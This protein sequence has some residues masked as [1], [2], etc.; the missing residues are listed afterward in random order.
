LGTPC[1][2]TDEL[3]FAASTVIHGVRTSFWHSGWVA[4]RRPKDIALD[5]CAISKRKNR[6]LRDALTANQWIRDI[7]TNTNITV[8]H[9]QQF[10]ELW[11]VTE[12]VQLDPNS[13]DTITWRWTATGEYSASS[14]Y[15]AKFA[16]SIKTKLKQIIWKP[17]ALQKC[18]FFAWLVTKYRVWTSD[19][20]A[21]R[22]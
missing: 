12:N 18:K 2:E 11:G 13:A 14:A 4:G 19:R 1:D 10:V 6:C 16:G 20:L 15:R 5:V 9:I 17:C 3:L 21:T 7:N 8:N 22:G